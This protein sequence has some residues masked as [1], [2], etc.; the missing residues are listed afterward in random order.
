[1]DIESLELAIQEL[2]EERPN[3]LK[4][5]KRKRNKL[6]DM[7]KQALKGHLSYN[8]T[9]LATVADEY[10]GHLGQREIATIDIVSEASN[11]AFYLGE[12]AKGYDHLNDIS[13]E[14]GIPTKDLYLSKVVMYNAVRDALEVSHWGVYKK[15]YVINLTFYDHSGGRVFVK[16]WRRFRYEPTT[17]SQ[18]TLA[19]GTYNFNDV[20][21]QLERDVGIEF[22]ALPQPLYYQREELYEYASQSDNPK[23][24]Q[25]MGLVRLQGYSKWYRV[26]EDSIMHRS[27]KKDELRMITLMYNNYE[28]EELHGDGEISYKLDGLLTKVKGSRRE[29][30]DATYYY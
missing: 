26:L 14:F 8:D 9:F 11:T 4:Q 18:F 27:R 20:K 12:S 2:L 28:L 15:G 13:D 30:E 6:K 25:Y 17:V 29:L 10:Q 5:G 22:S 7:R 21:E 24:Q 1:M 3:E 16:G 19:T 23:F